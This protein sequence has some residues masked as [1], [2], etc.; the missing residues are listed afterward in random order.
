MEMA[1]CRM[2]SSA[3]KIPGSGA[4]SDENCSASQ[5]KKH[6][7]NTKRS[8]RGDSQAVLCPT[9]CS[10]VCIRWEDWNS[11]YAGGSSQLPLLSPWFLYFFALVVQNLFPGSWPRCIHQWSAWCS[12]HQCMRSKKLVWFLV[13]EFLQLS[14]E[15][16]L[17]LL[18]LLSIKRI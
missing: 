12:P 11:P 1:F 5:D 10:A 16:L 4:G 15:S 17:C 13:V 9:L 2:L 3:S 8:N 6:W 7:G 14:T 18:I